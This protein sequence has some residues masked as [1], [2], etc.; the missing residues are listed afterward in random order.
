MEKRIGIVSNY[1][2]N[3][4]V[5]S[6]K[7]TGLLKVGDKIKIVGGGVE[8][9]QQVESMQMQ[10]EK[11][12]K[13]KKNLI[14]D[15]SHGLKT[16]ITMIEMSLGIIGNNLD[17]G[18]KENFIKAKKIAE[19]NIKKVRRDINS[20]LNE[21]SIDIKKEALTKDKMMVKK[22]SLRNSI[23]EAEKDM[24]SF[25]KSKKL[26][27]N[28]RIPLNTDKIRIKASDLKTLLNNLLENAIKFTNGGEIS[29]ISRLKGKMVEIEIKDTG[30]GIYRKDIN[31][32]FDKFYKRHAS[33]DGT[34]L[35]LSIC[36]ELVEM[37][38]GKIK[39]SSK[40]VG[41]GATVMVRLPKG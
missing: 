12:E 8:A 27:L 9:E 26:K 13:A 7:L 11:V 6:I 28:I 41:K 5:A 20:I 32:V 14:R 18:N 24:R 19:E 40:G 33:I 3:I 1:F 22:T 29:V 39:I 10:Y 38:D 16:P 34:G 35:G 37:Y 4:G 21:F 31:R 25:V 36:K 30:C 23:K 15:L 17:S 2:A